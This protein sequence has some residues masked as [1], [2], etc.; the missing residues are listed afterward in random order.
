[1]FGTDG[2]SA[3]VDAFT[4][5]FRFSIHL[6][7]FNHVRSN[8][9]R[10][11]QDRKF[12]ENEVSEILELI[13]G[14]LVGGTFSEGLVDAENESLFYEKLEE[15][16]HK[17]ADKEKENPGSHPGFFEWLC[18][19]KVDNIV[20]GMFKQVREEAGLGLPS[21]SFTTNACESINAMLK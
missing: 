19:Y 4:H 5:E 9:K 20:S 17:M 16:K 15:F 6:Y 7:C 13:F 3:L 12:P 18:Q 2:E 11:L 14:K 8:I 1:M 21:S 10:E